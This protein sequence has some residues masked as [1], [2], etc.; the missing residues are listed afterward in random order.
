[1]VGGRESRQRDGDPK[2]V[3]SPSLA[4]QSRGMFI[5]ISRLQYH[6]PALYPT[7]RV[8]NHPHSFY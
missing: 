6:S 8:A 5:A 3:R 4:K 2:I 1:M 7:C